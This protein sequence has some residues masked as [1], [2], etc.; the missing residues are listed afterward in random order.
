MVFMYELVSIYVILFIAWRA[1]KCSALMYLEI[2][3]PKEAK[4]DTWDKES[5]LLCSSSTL[6]SFNDRFLDSR[7]QILW[8]DS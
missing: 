5:Y 2:S 7:F 4:K 8:N 3:V 6:D 1:V